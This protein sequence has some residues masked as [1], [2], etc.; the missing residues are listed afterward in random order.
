MIDTVSVYVLTCNVPEQLVRII[1]SFENYDSSFLQCRFIVI[2]NSTDVDC[3]VKNRAICE[4]RNFIHI[5]EGNLG[6]TGGRIRAAID[7]HKSGSNYMFY[8]EDDMTLTNGRGRCRWGFPQ[9]VPQL[10]ETAVHILEAEGLDYLKLSFHE[11]HSDHSKDWSTGGPASYK[12]IGHDRFGYMIGNVYYSNW[13]MVINKSGNN[14]LFI[15]LPNGWID[16]FSIMK[17]A[18][19]MIG[20]SILKVGVLCAWPIL[21]KRDFNYKNARLENVKT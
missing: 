4:K 21:H 2:D 6:I 8:F 13:P 16:E 10:R 7:F 12:K 3:V 9:Y 15:A 17:K 14:K 19:Q 1:E 20:N 5:S 18:A 11:H